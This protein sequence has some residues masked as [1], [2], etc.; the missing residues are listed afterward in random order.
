MRRYYSRDDRD[1]ALFLLQSGQS[2]KYGDAGD[3]DEKPESS[4]KGLTSF[5]QMANFCENVTE[6]RHAFIVKVIRRFGDGIIFSSELALLLN[7]T[8]HSTL[9]SNCQQTRRNWRGFASRGVMFAQIQPKY[10]RL[11]KKDIQKKRSLSDRLGSQNLTK[12]M[13]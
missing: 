8:L 3:G 5:S 10:K 12:G 1:R 4:S 11:S 7:T 9:V 2:A 6:C 13:W